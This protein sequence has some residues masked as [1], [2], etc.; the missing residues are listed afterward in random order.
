[1]SIAREMFRG[2]SLVFGVQVIRDGIPQDISGW[3]M[4]CTVKY[5]V[6]DPDN[7]AVVQLDSTTTGIDFTDPPIG[8]AEIA[9]PASATLFFPDGVVSLV[10]DV[11]VKD[12][13]GRIFT[14][15][16]GTIAVSPDVTRAT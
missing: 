7:R 14:V 2:D 8:K 16:S 13:L 1:M 10:Y 6:Q 12:L 15:E 4:W 11:Q 3:R 5:F 9:M